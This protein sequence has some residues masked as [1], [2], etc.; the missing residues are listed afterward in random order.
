MENTPFLE[1]ARQLTKV[2]AIWKVAITNL[3]FK[4]KP[5]HTSIKDVF[6]KNKKRKPELQENS[7]KQCE[8]EK[9]SS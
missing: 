1:K 9:C 6:N 5:Q 4:S 7:T 2:R 8:G 3:S